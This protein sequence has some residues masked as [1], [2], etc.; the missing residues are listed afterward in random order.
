MTA[1]GEI[2]TVV[3]VMKAGAVDFLE[4]PFTSQTLLAG[5]E[6]AIRRDAQ[7]RHKQMQRD[8]IEARLA[9]LTPRERQVLDLVVGGYINKEIAVHL[10]IQPRTVEVHRQQ[11]MK[12]LGAQSSVDLVRLALGARS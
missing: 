4:K 1:Y 3:Q 11:A 2:P 12:K 9:C 7:W 8:K 10:G 5:V 6:A